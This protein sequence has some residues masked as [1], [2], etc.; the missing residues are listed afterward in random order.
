MYERA[1]G[2][3]Y[4]T[5]LTTTQ[6]AA[7]VRA[8]IKAAQKELAPGGFPRG[9]KFSVRSSYFSGGSSIDINISGIEA[10]GFQI[11]TEAAALADPREFMPSCEQVTEQA[12]ILNKRVE[13]M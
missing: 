12:K 13:A 6:I 7:L 1:Y 5:K 3:K 4:D 11:V 9:L 10:A 2:T 8:E